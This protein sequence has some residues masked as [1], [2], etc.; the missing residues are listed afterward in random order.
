MRRLDGEVRRELLSLGA[1]HRKTVLKWS[2]DYDTDRR[3]PWD[4]LPPGVPALGTAPDTVIRAALLE[5]GE[6]VS[7]GGVKWAR[8]RRGIKA[9][10]A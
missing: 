7:L 1:W 2:R 6:K 8:S 10:K 4:D 9:Y 5:A 3:I